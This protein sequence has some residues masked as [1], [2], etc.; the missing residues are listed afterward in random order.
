[1]NLFGYDFTLDFSVTKQEERKKKATG[2]SAKRWSSSEKNALLRF[3]SENKSSEEI[4]KLLNRTIPSVN[5]MLAKI[6]RNV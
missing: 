6:K 3:H 2:F 1:M 5:S 4:G